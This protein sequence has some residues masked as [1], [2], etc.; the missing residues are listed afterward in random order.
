M[1]LEMDAGLKKMQSKSRLFRKKGK[2]V[3]YDIADIKR[4]RVRL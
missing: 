4:K 1:P 2:V 3:I